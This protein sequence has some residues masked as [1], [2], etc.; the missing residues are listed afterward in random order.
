MLPLPYRPRGDRPRSALGRLL[1]GT[2]RRAGRRPASSELVGLTAA[3][4]RLDVRVLDGESGAHHVVLDE[5]DLATGQ[6]RR[7]VLVDEDL[8]AL[9]L[10][11]VVVAAG[12]I[13]P[14]ELVRHPGAPAAND[15]YPQAPLGLP[16]LQTQI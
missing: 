3:A 8:H 2:G 7:A 10:D 4:A 15:A 16:F 12:L 5:V 6:V 13:F 9:G 1:H 11:H 14:A